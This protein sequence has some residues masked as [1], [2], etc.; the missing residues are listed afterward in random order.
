[1]KKLTLSFILIALLS[2]SALA[3]A[4]PKAS[5]AWNKVTT[6]ADGTVLPVTVMPTYN[7]YRGLLASGTDQA[8]INATAITTNAYLDTTVVANTIY[9]YSVTAVDPTNNLESAKST[10]V[11]FTFRLLAIPGS[12]TITAAP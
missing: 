9:W 8:K 11:T 5:L 7:A 3:Q 1:M 4:A 6:Y 2:I 12:L 10:F